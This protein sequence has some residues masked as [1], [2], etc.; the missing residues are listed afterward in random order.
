[1]RRF[2]LL[3]I[4][5]GQAGCFPPSSS[6]SSGADAGSYGYAA[7]TVELT[8]AGHHY[9]P[10][11]PDSTSSAQL[12]TSRDPVTGRVTESTLR[13]HA[14]AAQ[15]GATCDLT[16]DRFGDGIPPIAV[17]IYQVE[18]PTGASTPDGTVSPQAGEQV[19]SPQGAFRCNACDGA[20]FSVTALSPSRVDGFV[21][22]TFDDPSGGPSVQVTC[23]FA[24][25]VTSYAP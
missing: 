5:L 16:A 24:V 12:V 7:P 22:G 11:A 17:G 20:L 3:L 8:V 9:G 1:M 10:A 23:S 25:P 15:G 14:A 6:S 19:S 21:S 18:S 2:A 13:I 4:V